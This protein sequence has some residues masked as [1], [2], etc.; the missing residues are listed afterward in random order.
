[1]LHPHEQKYT[2]EMGTKAFRKLTKLRLLEIHNA[3]V[4]KGPD[5]LPDELRWIDWDKYPSN[6]LPAM[7]EADVLVGLRLRCSRLKQLWEGRT[8]KQLK[9]LKYVDLSDSRN[10]VG[11][12]HLGEACN[13]EELILQRCTSLVKVDLSIGL[14]KKLVCLNLAGCEKLRSLPKE[15]GNLE[16]LEE[17]LLDGTAV[18]ELPPSIGYLK[19]LKKLSLRK[20]SS[21]S[22]TS[23]SRSFFQ[24]RK[25]Q[26]T[27]RSLVLGP[28][29]GLTSL[30]SLDLTDCNLLEGAIPIDLGSFVS[31]KEL[32]LGGNN[33]ENLPSLNQL[34][35]LAHLELNRCKMLRELP[36]LPSRLKRLYANDCASLRVSA[37]RFAMCKMQF[38]LF[39]NCRKL[40][41]YGE[42][43]IV[44]STLLQQLLQVR[45]RH[46][47]QSYLRIGEN[48]MLPGR[49]IPEWFCNHSF[50]RNSVLL[51]LPHTFTG[52]I[53]FPKFYTYFAILE[54]INKVKSSNL[55]EVKVDLTFSESCHDSDPIVT[56]ILNNLGNTTCLEHTAMGIGDLRGLYY[57]EFTESCWNG[58]GEIVVNIRSSRPNIVVVK[59]WG[60]RLLFKD[61]YEVE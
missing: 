33:F 43:E 37:D 40:L 39:Q 30:T 59:K 35:Q 34:S 29:W 14:L 31:L 15:M 10:L 12:S 23:I 6:F 27:T 26:K 1:M 9:N 19:N 32:C 51:K 49:V 42:S 45:R 56:H 13:L 58:P 7:F 3:C 21:Q 54:V 41:D 28:I 57:G 2:I 53:V 5:Y 17:L 18:T 11:T 20:S 36:E 16:C 24:L 44:A 38:G 25:H 46:E 50:T 52:R 4:P 22:P 61:G 8:K 47:L 48:I 60:V 55:S